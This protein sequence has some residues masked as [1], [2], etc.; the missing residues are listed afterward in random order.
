MPTR[1]ELVDRQ[2]SPL[3]NRSDIEPEQVKE[4]LELAA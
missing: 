1:T 3:N 2:K 4:I